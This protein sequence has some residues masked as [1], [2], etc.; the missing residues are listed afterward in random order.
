MEVDLNNKKPDIRYLNEM[1]NVVYDKEWL[2]TAPNI[3][4]YY[5][6]R[7]IEEQNGIR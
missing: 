6:Y 7:S 1:K 3:E 5:M 2:K 4:L